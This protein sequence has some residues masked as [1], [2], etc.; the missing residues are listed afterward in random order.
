MKKKRSLRRVILLPVVAGFA[1]FGLVVVLF[2][3]NLIEQRV[4]KY[5]E[6]DLSQK[7]GA[8]IRSFEARGP[9]LAELLDL[10]T[11][12]EELA[13]IT[14]ASDT[15]RGVQ[16]ASRAA[17]SCRTDFFYILNAEGI[18]LARGND[19]QNYGDDLTGRP[20]VARTLETQES[21]SSVEMD[22]SLGLCQ[23]VTLPVIRD[24]V[25]S[26]LVA[27]GY[28]LGSS[29]AVDRY[30][31]LFSA[32]F[33]VF[34][35]DSRIAT[36]IT[37]ADGERIVGSKLENPAIDNMVTVLGEPYYGTNTIDG[38]EYSVSYLPIKNW[39]ES[40]LG[41][42]GMAIP[43]S[44]MTAMARRISVLLG[45]MILLFAILLVAAFFMLMEKLVNRPLAAAKTAMHEIAGGDGDLTRLIEV[46]NDTE[47][48]Q[49]I[50]DI[51]RFISMLR[52]IVSEMIV[53]QNEL[54]EISESMTAMSV[55][56]ASS[57][58]EIMANIKSVGAQ[59]EKQQQSIDSADAVI[60]RSVS[61]IGTLGSV[62]N[63][64]THHIEEASQN[65]L[66]MLDR[67]NAA[68]NNVATITEQ[69]GILGELSG[70][71]KRKQNDVGEKIGKIADQSR[72]LKEANDVI[73]KI[74]SQ[75]NLLAMNAAIEAAHAG[76]SGAGFS[77]VADEI[78]HLAETSSVQSKAIRNE[79][80]SIQQAIGE[81]VFSASESAHAFDELITRVGS[82]GEVVN[83]FAETMR[84]QQDE[85]RKVSNSLDEMNRATA[86]VT[87]ESAALAMETSSIKKEVGFVKEASALIGASM[88][89]MTLGAAEIN[90]SA[91]EVSRLA[92]S[93]KDT[94]K[95][96][97]EIIRK[98]TV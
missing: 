32:E 59:S 39:Q 54:T 51:N 11:G 1:L 33:S 21:F 13:A 73:T 42:I 52:G 88:D 19:P 77:V 15:R 5:I 4:G 63:T 94:V 55:E 7:T 3:G 75:T 10:F 95:R 68:S 65:I 97:D 78:R 27:A 47:I 71:G 38:K 91:H 43:R 90:E 9:E 60:E 81:V 58:T 96:M 48:G 12:S 17:A 74:A 50:D 76:E 24:G 89:E 45:I 86:S 20:S 83:E 23:I 70:E 69:F 67:L 98:F 35:Y 61:K 87:N 57:I 49:I 93:T 22:G 37:G 92:V 2:S 53:R 6:E 84:L 56:S 28:R 79:I 18:V 16:F 72:L 8:F 34:M 66:S 82:I 46:R 31:N 25:L 30:K 41:V 40:V 29:E 14:S 26:G 80:K 62:I 44:A 64:Q 36:T 85:V